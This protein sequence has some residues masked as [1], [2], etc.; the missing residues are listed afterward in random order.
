MIWLRHTMVFKVVSLQ[1]CKWNPNPNR[2]SGEMVQSETQAPHW[3]SH[4]RTHVKTTTIQQCQP[5][6]S[7][8]ARWRE[9]DA[10]SHWPAAPQES[11]TS[12][13]SGRSYLE[14]LGK[15]RWE[16]TPDAKP[17]DISP[18]KDFLCVIFFFSGSMK[19]FPVVIYFPPLQTKLQSGRFI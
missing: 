13:F 12:G 17:A 9:T 19:Y 7:A 14:K 10:W 5:A 2:K 6:I 1:A 8:L 16:K 4:L 11:A 3:I 15:E 18:T